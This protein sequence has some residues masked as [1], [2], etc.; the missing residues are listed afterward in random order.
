MMPS[1]SLD[2]VNYFSDV[3]IRVDCAHSL[4]YGIGALAIAND[5]EMEK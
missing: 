5:D 3:V 2:G 1:H 4:F